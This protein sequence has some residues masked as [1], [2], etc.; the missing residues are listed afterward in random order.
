MTIA[1]P[2]TIA[3]MTINTT[4]RL[5]DEAKAALDAVLAKHQDKVPAVS[6]GVTTK[7]GVVYTGYHGSRVYGKPEEGQVDKS[8]SESP[9]MLHT[10]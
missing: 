4:P 5:S 8:T 1:I 2:L 10:A 7:D 6:F 9:V 3:S